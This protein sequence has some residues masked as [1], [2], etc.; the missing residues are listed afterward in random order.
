MNGKTHLIIALLIVLIL[1]NYLSYFFSIEIML[2][3]MG[4]CLLGSLL[5]DIDHHNG[6]IRKPYIIL[7]FLIFIGYSSYKDG[8]RAQHVTSL[9]CLAILL[10]YSFKSRHRTFTHSILALVLYFLCLFKISMPGAIYLFIGYTSHLLSDSLTKN[11][12]PFFYPIIKKSFG[13]KAVKTGAVF[14]KIILVVGTILSVYLAVR[15]LVEN[16]S[17][18]F[19]F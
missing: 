9:I 16:Y 6:I 12:I 5:P 8:F 18:L 19:N 1:Y 13:I 4:F 2:I 11:G 10:T 15:L 3:C 17:S 14:E 7:L